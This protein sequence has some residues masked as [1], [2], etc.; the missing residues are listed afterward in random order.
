MFVHKG[1]QCFP[2]Q[3][4]LTMSRGNVS[5]LSSFKTAKYQHDMAAVQN[6][7]HR[8]ADYQEQHHLKVFDS[9]KSCVCSIEGVVVVDRESKCDPGDKMEKDFCQIKYKMLA[10]YE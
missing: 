3:S 8:E 7:Q 9:L 10:G 6:E 5:F 4:Q 1:V 2:L